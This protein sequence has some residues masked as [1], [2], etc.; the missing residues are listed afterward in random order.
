VNAANR[1]RNWLRQDDGYPGLR[2]VR[3][4]ATAGLLAAQ[5]VRNGQHGALSPIRKG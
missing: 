3:I 4:L 5:P 2:H 1:T